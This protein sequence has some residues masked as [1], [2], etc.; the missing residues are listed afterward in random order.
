MM[1]RLSSGSSTP[2]RRAR[3]RC[4][5]VDHHQVHAKVGLEGRPQELGFLLAHE[6]VVDVDAGQPVAHSA[7]DEGRRDGRVD[8][9][10][11]RADDPPVRARGGGVGVDA[12]ADGGHGRVDEV[13]RGPGGR[14]AGDTDHEVAQDVAAARRVDD[15]GMELDAVQ[16]ALRVG[17]AGERRA[18]RSGRSSG[19][20]PAAA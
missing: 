5:G 7:V 10:R 20:R 2:A 4:A 8:P 17:Q 3:K 18:R 9:A 11:E 12:L 19:S 1:R 16:V 14:D 13:G 15:L 6:P